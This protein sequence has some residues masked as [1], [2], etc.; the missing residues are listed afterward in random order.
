MQV[1][2]A[3]GIPAL[4]AVIALR[5]HWATTALILAAAFL[6]GSARYA[7][8]TQPAADDISRSGARISAIEGCVASDPEQIDDKIRFVLRLTRVKTVD[9]W[10]NATGDVLVSIRSGIGDRPELQYGDRVRVQASPY[11]PFAPSNPGSQSWAGYLA[12]QGI[13]S[14][15]SVKSASQITKLSGS[16]GNP[17]VAAAAGAKHYVERAIDATHSK[18]EASVVAGVILGTYSYLPRETFRSFSRTGTLHVLAASGYNCYILLLIA[19]PLLKRLRVLPKW[20]NPLVIALIVLY[21]LMVGPKPSLLR[22]GVTASILLLALPLKRV[23]NLTNLF[24]TSALVVLAMNPSDLFDVG[25]Q[26][27]FLAVGALILVAPTIESLMTTGALWQKERKW[28]QRAY[29]AV[30]KIAATAAAAAIGTTAITLVT[31]PVV[32]YYFNYFSLVSVPANMVVALLVPFIFLDA[33]ATAAFGWVP[34]LGAAIGWLGSQMTACML[35]AVNCLGSLSKAAVSVQS[36]GMMA[37]L[38]YY[39]VLAAALL[40]VRSRVAQE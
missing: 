13:Y 24:F 27:S 6:I 40:F 10:S 9:G 30:S 36:P 15:A 19:T 31:A 2:L 34:Y 8:S 38:G 33:V 26:L 25:F 21:V 32:A 39:V 23:A 16:R 18:T 20:R 4:V 35:G 22:A 28:Q 5:R 17:L 7:T 1:A 14:C 11:K 12:R 37:I 29:R 3:A